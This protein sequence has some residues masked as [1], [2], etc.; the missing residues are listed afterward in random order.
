MQRA[1]GE[2][3]WVSLRT[4]MLYD[5][6]GQ[7]TGAIGA[8][9]DITD[10]KQSQREMNRLIEIFEATSDLVAIADPD[11]NLLYL[12]AAAKR[13]VGVSGDAEHLHVRDTVSGVGARTAHRRDPPG[14]RPRRP[15]GRRALARRRPTVA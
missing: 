1:D 11:G 3:R 4:S 7:P 14:R 8:I 13:F 10:R 15:L 6:D 12:N 2:V 5:D 9:E